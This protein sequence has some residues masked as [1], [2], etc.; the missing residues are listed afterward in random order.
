VSVLTRGGSATS[1]VGSSGAGTRD[2]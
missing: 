1:S 2:C